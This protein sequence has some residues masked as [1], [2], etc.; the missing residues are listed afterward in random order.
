[1]LVVPDHGLVRTPLRSLEEGS[2]KNHIRAFLCESR[3]GWIALPML[4]GCSGEQAADG[5][6]EPELAPPSPGSIGLKCLGCSAPEGAAT[7]EPVAAGNGI[8]SVRLPQ[9]NALGFDLGDL[10]ASR[11]YLFL[12]VNSGDTPVTDLRLSSSNPSFTVEPSSIDRLPPQAEAVVLPII[13]VGAIHGISVGGVGTTALLPAG[14]NTTTLD[15]SGSTVDVDGVTTTLEVQASLRVTAR[16]MDIDLYDGDRRVALGTPD[17]AGSTSLG[18]IGFLWGYNAEEP[19]IVNIGNVEI[20]VSTY[21][22][23]DFGAPATRSLAVG[24]M[25][26]VERLSVRLQSNTVADGSRFQIGND[27][28]AYFRID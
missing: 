11:E 10:H 14:A 17:S 4:V 7:D 13:R 16:V 15:V 9:A 22:E 18:G 5:V 1:M 2:M 25:L 6:T 26:E 12:L 20:Q 21:P 23:G 28:A 19:R 8:G 24:A 3:V 27:G